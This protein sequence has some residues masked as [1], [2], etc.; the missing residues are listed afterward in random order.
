MD[1]RGEYGFWFDGKAGSK[2]DWIHGKLSNLIDKPTSGVMVSD[3]DT[4]CPNYVSQW[5]EYWEH[6][7]TVNEKAEVL[8]A[9]YVYDSTIKNVLSLST[10]MIVL[11]AKCLL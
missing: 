8:C 10:V 3:E 4:T 1:E 9:D 11:I 6:Q 7:W 2:A 5:K